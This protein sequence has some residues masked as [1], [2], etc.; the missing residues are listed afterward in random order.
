[1]VNEESQ[2]GSMYNI[3][4]KLWDVSIQ[5]YNCYQRNQFCIGDRFKTLQICLVV[6]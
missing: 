3:R 6:L 1:M 4:G 5:A 2:I